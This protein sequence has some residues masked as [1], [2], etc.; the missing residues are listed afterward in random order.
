MTNVE[1]SEMES[2][3]FQDM[4]TMQ[5]GKPFKGEVMKALLSA[6]NNTF[7]RVYVFKLQRFQGEETTAQWVTLTEAEIVWLLSNMYPSTEVEMTNGERRLI[8]SSHK[9]GDKGTRFLRL[10]MH[11]GDKKRMIQFPAWDRAAVIKALGFARYA[12]RLA[13]QDAFTLKIHTLRHCVAF[14][15]VPR[16]ICD[17]IDHGEK[18]HICKHPEIIGKA[19]ARIRDSPDE[20]L[21][22]LKKLW[23]GFG[24]DAD[25]DIEV[26]AR[27]HFPTGPLDVTLPCPLFDYFN[28]LNSL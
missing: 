2:S 16:M 4:F 8:V 7:G 22:A 1:L 19:I 28:F 11:I 20:F 9:F 25:G 18:N 12:T 13:S 14:F 3:K 17:D 15:A 21:E 5:I 27:E 24:I 10:T 23:Q 26:F 6:T